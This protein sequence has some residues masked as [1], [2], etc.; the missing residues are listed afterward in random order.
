MLKHTCCYFHCIKMKGSLN[1]YREVKLKAKA[2]KMSA[3]GLQLPLQHCLGR[4]LPQSSLQARAPGLSL[5][6][7]FDILVSSAHW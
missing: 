3:A 5:G 2:T 6:A 4:F 1:V 7:L